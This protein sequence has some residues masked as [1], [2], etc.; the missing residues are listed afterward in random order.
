VIASSRFDQ[1]KAYLLAHSADK[2]AHSG[3]TLWNHLS[4]VHR[5]LQGAQQ[6]EYVCIAGLFHS[7]YGT[8]SFKPVTIEKSRR[9]EVAELIG[10]EAEALAF[11]FCELPRPK[12]L[13]WALATT[14]FP[15]Q[16]KPYAIAANANAADQAEIIKIFYQDLLA[17]E[18]ANLLEQRVLHEFPSLARHAQSLRMLDSEGFCI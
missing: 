11:A 12:L 1:Y 18:C 7:V 13:E 9:A 15:E 16:I 2:Q 6:P 3:H 17:M 14:Q 8:Q 10:S 4:G 5:I